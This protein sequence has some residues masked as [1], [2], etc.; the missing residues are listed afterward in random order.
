MKKGGRLERDVGDW[1]LGVILLE[2]WG[3]VNIIAY[4]AK[5]A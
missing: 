5:L 2:K 3:N 1:G 4:Y